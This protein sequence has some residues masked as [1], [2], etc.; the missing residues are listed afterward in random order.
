MMKAKALNKEAAKVTTII[1]PGIGDSG[2]AHWQSLWQAQTPSCRRF[3][4][5]D[6]DRPQLD[7]WLAALDR[8][9]DEAAEA[10]DGPPLLI[11]HSLACLLV[12]HGAVRLK[13]RIRGA[14]LVAP[15]DPQ[16]AAFPAEAAS[17]AAV[18]RAP[19]AFPALV[20][21]SS[22][23]AY[24]DLAYALNLAADWRAGFVEAGALG[25]IN[26]ASGVGAWKQGRDLLTAFSAGVGAALK[27]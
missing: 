8:A 14:F 6:W 19:L 11:A 22:D 1:L 21:A 15:P 26:A 18:P 27:G 9:I 25:H 12:A 2:P 3:A 17:F 24:A 5:G 4:P 10:G 23:D 13:G 16:S 7:D 20:V